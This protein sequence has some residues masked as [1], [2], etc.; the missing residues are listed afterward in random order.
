MWRA[1]TEESYTHFVISGIARLEKKSQEFRLAN[2]RDCELRQVPSGIGLGHSVV[3]ARRGWSSCLVLFAQGSFRKDLW[4]DWKKISAGNQKGPLQLIKGTERSLRLGGC[5]ETLS[6]QRWHSTACANFPRF[7]GV[8][9]LEKRQKFITPQRVLVC[10]VCFPLQTLG[11]ISVY[12]ASDPDMSNEGTPFLG[13]PFVFPSYG[14]VGPPYIA[15]LSLPGLTIGLSVW[16]FSTPVILNATSALV[17]STSPQEHQPHVDPSPSSPVRSPSPSSLARSS[18]VSSS[19]SSERCEASN[20]V[21]KKNKKRKITKK[22]NKQG[23][24]LPTNSEHVGK[25]PVTVDHVGSVDDAK[26]TQ[27][28]RKPKYPCKLCKGNHL[29]KD[30]PGLSKVIEA[31]CTRPCQPMSSSSEQHVDDLPSTS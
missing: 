15:T 12:M 8:L 11:W 1:L 19:L 24:K 5:A 7:S 13:E 31:W 14:N 20:P 23:S 28:T 6:R 21:D 27:T 30:C 4:I 17:V 29:L 3:V 10:V 26:I 9:S 2:S 16:L 25:K 18:S 22:K